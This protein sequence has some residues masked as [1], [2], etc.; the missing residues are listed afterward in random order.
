MY[1]LIYL[2]DLCT[3]IDRTY[4]V[5]L[6][7]G[8]HTGDVPHWSMCVNLPRKAISLSRV[9]ER[10]DDK[11]ANTSAAFSLGEDIKRLVPQSFS[12]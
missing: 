12:Q 9:L 11:N 8:A 10:G 7:Y 3:Q 5:S 6:Q 4:S 2:A 1:P